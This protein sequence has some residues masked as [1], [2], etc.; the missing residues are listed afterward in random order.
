MKHPGI[1]VLLLMFIIGCCSCKQGQETPPLPEARMQ[2]VLLDMHMAETY[3]LGLGDSTKNRFEKNYDSLAVFYNSILKHHHLTFKEFNDALNWYR[4]R[5]IAIDS[6]YTKVLNQL[7][8]L[9]ARKGIKDAEENHDASKPAAAAAVLPD[10][11]RKMN[12]ADTIIHAI[13]PPKPKTKEEP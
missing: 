12:K 7:N 8:E 1:P 6:L 11:L 2:A 9:K 5:P 10:S 3:S 4:E 13:V